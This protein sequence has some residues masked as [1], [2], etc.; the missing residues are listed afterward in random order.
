MLYCIVQWCVI[1]K[2]MDFQGFFC[3]ASKLFICELL[4]L[5]VTWYYTKMCKQYAG[6]KHVRLYYFIS[7]DKWCLNICVDMILIIFYLGT[8]NIPAYHQNICV[9]FWAEN[10]EKKITHNKNV[11]WKYKTRHFIVF[12]YIFRYTRIAFFIFFPFSTP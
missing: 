3:H 6:Y 12:I 4:T 7:Y 11:Y 2:G 9:V 5:F 8:F 10:K 1:H